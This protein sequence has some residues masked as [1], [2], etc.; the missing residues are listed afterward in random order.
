[1]ALKY[2]TDKPEE[3]TEELYQQEGD[4][5]ILQVE[6]AVGV[7]KLN[8]FRN[9]NTTLKEQ[10]DSFRISIPPRHGMRWSSSQSWT[11]RS[12]WMLAR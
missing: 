4:K 12:S 2:I 9:N 7:D 6:G 8:E 11:R 1:M 10:L 5:F 3:G